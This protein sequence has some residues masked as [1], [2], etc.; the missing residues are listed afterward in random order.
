MR[1]GTGPQ[2]S[3][4]LSGGVSAHMCTHTHTHTHTHKNTATYDL[5]PS[6][7]CA[8]SEQWICGFACLCQPIRRTAA[9]LQVLGVRGHSLARYCSTATLPTHTSLVLCFYSHKITD[10]FT[11]RYC[12][13]VDG[14]P[15]DFEEDSVE[16]WLLVV[17]SLLSAGGIGFAIVCIVFDLVFRKKR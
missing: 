2:A 17:L 9:C 1:M 3:E 4:Y 12:I 6:S 11:H 16:L 14:V 10:I 13:N 7:P 15:Q 5:P 8:S